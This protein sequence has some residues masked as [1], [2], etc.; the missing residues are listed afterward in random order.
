MTLFRKAARFATA[1]LLFSGFIF[2]TGCGDTFRPIADPINTPGGDPQSSDNV[3][4]IHS[5]GSRSANVSFINVS[6]DTNVGNKLIGVGPGFGSY[7]PSHTIV[8]VP[9]NATNSVS[10]VSTTVTNAVSVGL[11][12]GSNVVGV[13]P[14]SNVVL[15]LNASGNTEC[16]VA[17]IGLIDPSSYSNY[18]NICL[19]VSPSF[20]VAA[21]GK[22]YATNPTAG[23]LSVVDYANTAV[24]G[25]VPVGTNPVHA[26]FS[27]ESAYVFV[28]N[29]GSNDISVVDTNTRTVVATVPTGGVAP[30]F[31]FLDRTL[32]RLYVVNQGS[33]NVSVFDASNA[34][35][36][37]A[38]T[39]VPITVGP[40][41]N[42]VTVISDGSKAYVGNTGSNKVTVIS[43][44]NFTTREITVGS[45]PAATVVYVAASRN[46][47]KVYAATVA[48]GNLA[49]GTSVISTSTDSVVTTIPAPPQDTACTTNCVLQVPVQIAGGRT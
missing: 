16:A 38:L 40:S 1:A 26:V 24:L 36:L 43:T 17:S 37:R 27:L 20:A 10:V 19:T 7:D 25:A 44:L 5:N 13:V 34:V 32:N 4:V 29:K 45:D 21:N 14:V 41:P 12:P 46:G 18:G 47:S 35:G 31:G 22:L 39:S 15:T 28:I 49:N 48:P 23:T 6:G 30:V 9:N 42:T 8:F 3:A 11:Q 2:A 33:N